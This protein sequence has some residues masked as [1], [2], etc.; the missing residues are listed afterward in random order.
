[1]SSMGFALRTTNND[2]RLCRDGDIAIACWHM[3]CF[4]L[5]E[6]DFLS[7]SKYERKVELCE[8]LSVIL[9]DSGL[10]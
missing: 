1:M 4:G 2:L 5:M 3:W 6:N 10:L 9:D 7:W 8:Y